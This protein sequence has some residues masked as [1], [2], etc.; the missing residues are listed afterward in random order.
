MDKIKKILV[1]VITVGFV[2]GHITGVIYA[3]DTTSKTEHPHYVAKTCPTSANDT[4]DNQ[5]VDGISF[6]ITKIN[7]GKDESSSYKKIRVKLTAS[8]DSIWT[9]GK[10]FTGNSI[11]SKTDTVIYFVM[12]KNR[13]YEI[14][15]ASTIDNTVG[16]YYYGNDPLKDAYVYIREGVNEEVST[17]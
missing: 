4:V 17:N 3:A 6:Y 12:E 9:P 7:N 16:I 8:S 5:V 1:T 11:L 10:G 14:F 2:L 13:Y 15:T